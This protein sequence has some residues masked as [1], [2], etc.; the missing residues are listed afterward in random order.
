MTILKL[1]QYI[2][3]KEFAKKQAIPEWKCV[4]YTVYSS[5]FASIG[6][7]KSGIILTVFGRF[8][9]YEKEFPTL[10]VPA[11]DNDPLHFSSIFVENENIPLH[12]IKAMVDYSHREVLARVPFPI[13]VNSRYD[14][15]PYCG[16]APF[17]ENS[18]DTILHKELK[19]PPKSTTENL[20]NKNYEMY[21]IVNSANPDEKHKLTTNGKYNNIPYRAIHDELKRKQIIRLLTTLSHE[22]NTEED[23]NNS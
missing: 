17:Y 2:M 10:V 19:V 8:G 18:S 4:R 23:D 5:F 20:P 16:I 3:G 22:N 15:V 9:H 6:E 11:L 13:P 12:A 21:R 14:D 7:S 1:E